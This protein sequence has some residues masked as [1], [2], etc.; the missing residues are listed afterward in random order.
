MSSPPTSRGAVPPAQEK[1]LVARS[2]NSC[3][4][5]S[6]GIEL[7]V[8]AR[9]RDDRPKAVG[10]VAHIAAAS[11]GGPRFDPEMT[12][13]QRGSA[14]NLIYLCGPHHDAIDS[15][16][17]L[18]TREFLVA[19][20]SSHER[21]VAK[22]MRRAMGDV[23]Y[24]ELNLVCQVIVHNVEVVPLDGADL[25]LPVEE[26]II[27]NALGKT[28]EER[29]KEGLAQAYRVADFIA[30][31]NKYNPKFGQSLVARMKADYF[32]ALSEGLSPDEVFDYIVGV[33][34]ENAGLRDTEVTRAAAIAVVAHVFE[35][36][37]IFDRA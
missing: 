27:L 26:K 22:A 28:V 17:A 34:N 18:H 31:Q 35:L 8:E 10:K 30:F 11:A 6:C 3:A 23:T 15:Q 2:G 7:V 9:H 4:Y 36:C 24:T 16:L 32:V 13:Q 25:P 5:P 29:I 1:V 21:L 12:P 37:E 33:A 14:S 20:K 19:A